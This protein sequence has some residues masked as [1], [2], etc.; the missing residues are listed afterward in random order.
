MPEASVALRT[1]VGM[2]VLLP[3]VPL[4]ADRFVSPVG[5]GR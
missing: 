5:D 2:G 1:L 3:A 4:G